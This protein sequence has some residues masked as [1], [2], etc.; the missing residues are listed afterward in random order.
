MRSF[1]MMID[2]GNV[3]SSSKLVDS[4]NWVAQSSVGPLKRIQG[5][6]SLGPINR[7]VGFFPEL[8]MFST[9]RIGLMIFRTRLPT[10]LGRLARIIVFV[11]FNRLLLKILAANL[12]GFTISGLNT[13]ITRERCWIVGASL[14]DVVAIGNIG[15]AYEKAKDTYIKAQFQCQA[16]PNNNILLDL[17]LVAANQFQIQEKMYLSFLH[18]RRKVNWIQKGDSNTAYFHAML[19]K[20][21][22]ENKIVSFLTEQGDLNDHFPDV[23]QHF[24]DHFRGIMGNVKPTFVELQP[25]NIAM[26]PKINLDQQVHLLKP[27]SLKEVRV[28]TFSIPNTK[29]P[30]PDGFGSGFFQS[31]WPKVGKD[32]HMAIAHFFDT[33]QFPTELHS[34]T[35]S[36]IPKTESPSKAID[37]RPIACC[38]TLY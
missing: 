11:W 32:I 17:E 27:F 14:L 18:Q 23:V 9:M 4:N 19:K 10:S 13:Q 1:I 16:N 6:I 3:I 38:T 35:L 7:T 12:F 21:K 26:G 8:I 29:S 24:L 31:V 34:T 28:G 5:R 15:E 33:N 2:R 36:L 37:Y 30:R 22:E 20:R 25:E